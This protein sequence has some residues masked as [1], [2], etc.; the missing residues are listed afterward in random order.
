MPLPAC[1]A[2]RLRLPAIAAPMFLCSGPALVKA[3][4]RAGMVGSFP[5]LNNRTAAEL[6]AW[7]ADIAADLARAPDAAP[8][9]VNLIVRANNARLEEDIAICETHRVPIVITSLGA[10]RDLVER[11]HGWGGVVFHD[12]V[13]MR[14]ATKAAEAGVDGLILV[15]AGAGGH[16]GA[17]SPFAL[18]PEVRR[19]FA[20]TVILAGGMSDGRAIAAARAL[21][22]DLA[23]FGTRFIATAESMAPEDYKRMIV[24][25]RSSDVLYTPAVSGI[26][27]N[28]LVPSIVANGIDP[29]ALPAKIEPVGRSVLPDLGVSA[30]AWRD[31][32]SAGQGVGTI[33]DIPPAADLIARLSREYE[34]TRRELA[35]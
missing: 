4:C 11:V 16:A 1:L 29:A 10:V 33:D 12:I 32:W 2:G 27:A 6:D 20:G 18:V 19:M 13:N 15:C 7:L 30:K 17:L 24:S 35:A 8:Y 28:F 26:P 31:V 5:S 22:A 25:A 21:G 34:A 14:H 23:Y 3:V 9:A